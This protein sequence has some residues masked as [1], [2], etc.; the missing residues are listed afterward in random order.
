[1]QDGH[2]SVLAGPLNR[3]VD[4]WHGFMSSLGECM[5]RGKPYSC[6]F[7]FRAADIRLPEGQT[8]LR[9]GKKAEALR[10]TTQRSPTIKSRKSQPLQRSYKI[11]LTGYA[12]MR[13]ECM[14][15]AAFRN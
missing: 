13:R 5:R 3:I 10:T 9:P 4:C 2:L 11:K 14:L 6:V 12:S 8:R 15:N 1:M 7:G